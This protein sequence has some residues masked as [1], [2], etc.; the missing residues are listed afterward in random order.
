MVSQGK[1][2]Y[3][4]HL[5]PFLFSSAH[6]FYSSQPGGLEQSLGVWSAGGE[7]FHREERYLAVSTFSP[8]YLLGIGSFENC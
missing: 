7:F 8:H 2:N 4:G 5:C 6:L 3:Q 1:S